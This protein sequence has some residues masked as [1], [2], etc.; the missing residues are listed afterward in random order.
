M[1]KRVVML[2]FLEDMLRKAS[3]IDADKVVGVFE[4][5]PFRDGCFNLLTTSF[6]LRDARNMTEAIKEFSRVL[7]KNGKYLILDLGKPNN[8]IA[9]IVYAVYWRVIA[10]LIAMIR[11]G[12]KGMNAA[13]IYPTYRRLPTNRMLVKILREGFSDVIIK[14]KLMGGVV[15]VRALNPLKS[16]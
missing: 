3:L 14:E 2:D 6:A 1:I 7:R 12:P 8:I 16:S 13:E 11:L 4:N 15:I 9:R 5:L 10:P